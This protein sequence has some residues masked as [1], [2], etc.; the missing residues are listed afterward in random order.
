MTNNSSDNTDESLK[1]NSL[2]IPTFDIQHKTVGNRNGSNQIST[3][4]F[5]IYYNSKDSSLLENLSSKMFWRSQ[6]QFYLHPIRTTTNNKLKNIQTIN[7][8]PKQ[9]HCINIHYPHLWSNQD[10]NDRQIRVKVTTS[11]KN[12]WIERNSFIYQ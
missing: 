6:Q 12:I 8:L 2:L 7:Y 10:S 11:Y 4:A 1:E 9:I 3:T 5:N